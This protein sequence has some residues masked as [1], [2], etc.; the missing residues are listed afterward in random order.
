MTVSRLLRVSLTVSDLEWA[1]AFYRDTLDFVRVGDGMADDPAWQR[2][3][4]AEG[5][6][7][8]SVIMRL[9]AQ[10]IELVAFDPPG[11]P[12]PAGSTA[13]DPWFQHLA[14]VVRDMG[15]AWTRVLQANMAP[16]SIDGPQLL[17]PN[18]GSVTAF[19]FRDPDGHP[20]ELIAF[21][22]G[23]G[24]PVWQHPATDALFLGYD[25]SAIVVRDAAR[26]TAFYMGLLGF[27]EMAHSLNSGIGQERLDGTPGDVVDVVAL[28]P[29]VETTPHVELLGYRV[30]SVAAPMDLSVRD[31]ASARLVLQVDALA[32][33]APALRERGVPL[34]SNSVVR[35]RDGQAALQVSD[36]DGHRL[37]LIGSPV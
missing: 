37:L 10:E 24:D 18:T 32:T 6:A 7:A 35:L 28:A 36:P 26:S 16:I 9:G 31:V 29:G 20:L 5:A 12:Y 22:A 25:H 13:Y 4:G 1:E 8:R 30:P 15:A 34:L 14:I 33:L 21:P 19:K 11:R 2:V 17:P 23:V 27:R 3:M